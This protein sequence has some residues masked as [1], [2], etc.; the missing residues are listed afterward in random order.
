MLY[1]APNLELSV[2]FT[3]VTNFR[4]TRENVL[5]LRAAMSFRLNLAD[6]ICQGCTGINLDLDIKELLLRPIPPG[7]TF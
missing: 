4:L 6:H 7:I 1:K 5:A 2:N 3:R